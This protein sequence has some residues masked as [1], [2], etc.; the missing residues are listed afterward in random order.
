MLRLLIVCTANVTRSPLAGA[1]LQQRL[2]PGAARISTAGLRAL[3]GYPADPVMQ[4]L[5]LERGY[6]LSAHRSQPVLPVM[7]GQ[8]DLVLAMEDRQVQALLAENPMLTGRVRRFAEPLPGLAEVPD[9]T[10]RARPD[11][12]SCLVTV[13]QLAGLWQARLA[14]MGFIPSLPGPR[15]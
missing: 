2:P 12:Q 8:Q 5:A 3:P 9:P 7:L 14:Q 4:E 6:D 10:G 15:A 1:I 13:E 11:Y